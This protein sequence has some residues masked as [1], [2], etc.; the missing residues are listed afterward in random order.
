MQQAAERNDWDAAGEA[1]IQLSLQTRG[2]RDRL[3]IEVLAPYV[4]LRDAE[5]VATIAKDLSAADQRRG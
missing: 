5:R 4:R 3:R 2:T 1:Y